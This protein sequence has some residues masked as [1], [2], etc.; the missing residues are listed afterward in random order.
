MY[1]FAMITTFARF[2][3]F[4]PGSGVY[5]KM[6]CQSA[7]VPKRK[8]TFL[9]APMISMG[10]YYMPNMVQIINYARPFLFCPP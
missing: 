6:K 2:G 5:L 10:K 1:P 4:S 9:G 3:N 8:A 7:R